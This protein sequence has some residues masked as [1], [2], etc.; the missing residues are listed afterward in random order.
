MTAFTNRQPAEKTKEQKKVSNLAWK[1][2]K[3]RLDMQQSGECV[4]VYVSPE[5]QA[6]RAAKAAAEA[7]EKEA[8]KQAGIAKRA[9][10]LAAKKAAKVKKA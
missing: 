4:Q 9:A 10:T 8:R 6:K 7:A 2:S 5:V 3:I 1:P